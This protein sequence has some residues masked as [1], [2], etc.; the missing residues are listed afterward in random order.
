MILYQDY[1]SHRDSSE[2]RER[3]LFSYISIW[4]TVKIFLSETTGLIWIWLGRN[5]SLG[6]PLPRLFKPSCFIKKHKPRPLMAMFLAHLEPK[7]QGE[8]L[9]S[10]TVRRHPSVRPSTMFKQHL[11][12]NHWLEFDQTSQEWSLVGP[13]SKLFKWFW[14]IAY[15]G[16]RS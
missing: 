1:S 5:V 11:L 3:S 13:L 4:K 7:A 16:H 6:D 14:S 10:L 9:W 2:N 12:L 8:L 15:L